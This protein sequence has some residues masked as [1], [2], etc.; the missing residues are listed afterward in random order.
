M[1]KR[2]S[3]MAENFAARAKT[4]LLTNDELTLGVL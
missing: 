1:T 4:P 3:P 2:G